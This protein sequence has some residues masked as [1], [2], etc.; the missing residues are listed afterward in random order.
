MFFSNS[1]YYLL[2]HQR[3]PGLREYAAD[4]HIAASA[5]IARSAKR[6]AVPPR[7]AGRERAVR[8]MARRSRVPG[9]RGHR[10]WHRG[11][12]LIPAGLSR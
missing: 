12:P 1:T 11:D 8:L 10:F 5:E 9:P 3:Q 2:V 6:L 4:H 7:R